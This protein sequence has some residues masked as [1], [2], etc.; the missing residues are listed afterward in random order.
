MRWVS[1]AL[2][3]LVCDTAALRAVAPV[4]ANNNNLSRLG[5]EFGMIC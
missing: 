1:C 4:A 3:R 5:I 2:L